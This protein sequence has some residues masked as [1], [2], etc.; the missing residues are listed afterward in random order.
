MNYWEECISTA[1]DECG[2]KLTKE[3]L[4]YLADAAEGGH[5]NYGMAF[6]HDAIPNQIESRAQEE[7]K[8]LQREK[9]KRE[10]WENST[11]PCQ[12]CI[13]TG[14][15]KDGLGRDR[16]CPNCDGKGRVRY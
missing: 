11:M 8:K 14:N 2:L 10:D 15:V 9:Q 7:L 3:Q 13:T 5:E 6:G 4:K 16:T 12:I 1:A